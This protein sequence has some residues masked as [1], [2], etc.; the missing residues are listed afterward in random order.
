MITKHEY[1]LYRK[2]KKK[3]IDLKGGSEPLKNEIT[4]T[5]LRRLDPIVQEQY[6]FLGTIRTGYGLAHQLQTI[7]MYALRTYLE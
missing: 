2:Y 7:N 5:E 4:E 6:E 1:Y 3:Y